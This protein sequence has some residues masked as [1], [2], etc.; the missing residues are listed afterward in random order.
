MALAIARGRA[1]GR[2]AV[3]RRARGHRLPASALRG[4]ARPP[5][6][7]T[8]IESGLTVPALV[9][10]QLSIHALEASTGMRYWFLPTR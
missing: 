9:R 1:V 4:G 2:A 7:G 3:G 6:G 8:T 5:A 10:Y